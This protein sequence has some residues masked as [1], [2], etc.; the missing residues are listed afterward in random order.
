MRLAAFALVALLS[1][2]PALAETPCTADCN[3]DFEVTVNEIIVAVNI[4][5]GDASLG[6]CQPADGT[7][8]NEITVDEIVAAVR[9]ALEGCPTAPPPT[10]TATATPT[11]AIA[12]TATPVVDAQNPPTSAAALRTWLMQGFYKDWH[13]ES[14]PH[15]SGGPHG[16]MVRTYFNDLVFNSLT[17]GNATHP[18]GAAVVK[19]LYFGGATVVEWGVEIKLDANSDRGKNW[20]WYEGVGLAGKGLGACTGCHGGNFGT[21]VSKDYVLSVFPLQ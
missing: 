13:A 15:P 1:A 17:A 16:G 14:A 9:F 11:V 10:A 18:K 6:Q 19:E 12:A 7:G 20:Y 21:Y 8:D 4:A 5:L 2:L 3:G